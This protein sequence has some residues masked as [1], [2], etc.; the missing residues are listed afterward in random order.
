MR[1]EDS[2]EVHRGRNSLVYMISWT[3]TQSSWS[4]LPP[5]CCAWTCLLSSIPTSQ[6]TQHFHWGSSILETLG[7]R[8]TSSYA[9]HSTNVTFPLQYRHFYFRRWVYIL[10]MPSTQFMRH[11][12]EIFP[13]N[14]Q[15][16][17]WWHI[18]VWN[19][20]VLRI[21]SY[22]RLLRIIVITSHLKL[23]N[24]VK[25][26]NCYKT[27]ITTWKHWIISIRQGFLKPF[28]CV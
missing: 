7:N 27:E 16:E 18:V 9:T 8:C 10:L 5:T 28:K 25:T 19:I 1:V 17:Y 23:N 21:L 11:V 20:Y 24:W 15:R 14:I 2:W 22:T 3:P 4:L 26:N 13:V 12:K 6:L